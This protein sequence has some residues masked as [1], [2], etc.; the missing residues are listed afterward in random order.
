MSQDNMFISLPEILRKTLICN[1]YQFVIG[2]HQTVSQ[3]LAFYLSPSFFNAEV[4]LMPQTSSLCTAASDNL[5][6]TVV[7]KYVKIK[8]NPLEAWTG[9]EGS[10]I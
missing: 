1:Q 6:G 2:S 3:G 7:Y 10:R 4:I 9:P 8:G 5:V